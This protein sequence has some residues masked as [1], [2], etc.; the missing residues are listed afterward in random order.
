MLFRIERKLFRRYNYDLKDYSFKNLSLSNKFLF[1]KIRIIFNSFHS[2]IFK[3]K[4]RMVIII[5]N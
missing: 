5:L 2:I 1:I 3:L 4:K